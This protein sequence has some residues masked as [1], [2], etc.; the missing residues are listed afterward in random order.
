MTRRLPSKL[1]WGLIMVNALFVGV[2]AVDFGQAVFAA[3]C[4]PDPMPT[5]YP[6]GGEG[7]VAG[8]WN[9]GS[10]QRY[11]LS[12]GATI[13]IVLAA[14][15]LPFWLHRRTTNLILLVAALPLSGMVSQMLRPLAVLI[16][17]E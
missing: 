7:P 2:F 9:Y 3:P 4:W 15:L 14:T 8:A 1:E 11:L 16:V 5:C 12:S 10:K 6:W 17:S 13:V